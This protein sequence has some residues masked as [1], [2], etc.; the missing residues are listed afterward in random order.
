MNTSLSSSTIQ[1]VHGTPK[2]Y[3]HAKSLYDVSISHMQ[4]GPFGMVLN[5]SNR[6]PPL[7]NKS[8]G[9]SVPQDPESAMA[10]GQDAGLIASL[11]ENGFDFFID[12]HE[13]EIDTKADF[14][15]RG[16]YGD[17][18]KAKWMG[19]MVAV[20]KFG[21]RYMSKK[22]LKD[23]I[24]EIEMLNQLRHPNIVLYMGVSLDLQSQSFFYMV[25]EFVSKGSLFDLL[26]QRKL[27][28][29][30]GRITAIAKQIAIALL[31]LHKRALFHCDLK[32][33][34]VLINEDW[35]VKLCDFGLS[36]YQVKFDSE[37][38]G[39]IGTPHWMAPEILRGEKYT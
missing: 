24:K 4:D 9:S 1:S 26:H 30:D 38:H 18:F 11:H 36:R 23:F 7:E 22:A 37:N 10:L 8:L 16:G 20:K 21:K 2:H 29:D 39:K 35:T 14:I 25:T 32:S 28:L 15:G 3:S 34:N 31:Y 12:Y 13:L 5:Q 27:V 33:Q 17:V 19:T 6:G